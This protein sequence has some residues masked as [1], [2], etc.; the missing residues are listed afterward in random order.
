LQSLIH[1]QPGIALSHARIVRHAP[2]V[3]GSSEAP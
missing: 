1:N 3:D 2:D